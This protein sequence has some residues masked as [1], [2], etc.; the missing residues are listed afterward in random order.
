MQE[1]LDTEAEKIL[2]FDYRFSLLPRPLVWRKSVRLLP[3]RMAS[4]DIQH[5]VRAQVRL[6]QAVRLS[7]I[8]DPSGRRRLPSIPC[9]DPTAFAP[10]CLSCTL[11]QLRADWGD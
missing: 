10:D 8:H 1:K 5:D 6:P 3:A 7:R 4:R 9:R 11:M 2:F